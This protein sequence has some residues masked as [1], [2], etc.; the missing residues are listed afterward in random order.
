MLSAFLTF[1]DRVVYPCYLFGNRH[2]SIAPLQDQEYAGALMWV[3]VTFVYA[4]PAVVIT[5]QL[6]STPRAHDPNPG[7][8]DLPQVMAR[9]LA[10]PGVEVV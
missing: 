5:T 1:C 9:P 3:C 10:G 8:G 4:V 6:L 2:F 7:R